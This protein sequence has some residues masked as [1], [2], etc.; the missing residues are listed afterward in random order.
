MTAANGL[1]VGTSSA[2][3]E[4]QLLCI[5]ASCELLLDLGIEGRTFGWSLPFRRNSDFFCGS[6]WFNHRDI[7]N[8]T[9]VLFNSS[10]D[11]SDLSDIEW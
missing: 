5:C 7:R 4:P 10:V 6:W 11:F 2:E 9:L 1:A 3:A 8:T